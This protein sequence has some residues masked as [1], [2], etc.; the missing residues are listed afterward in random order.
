M[1]RYLSVFTRSEHSPGVWG[2]AVT[3]N[4][5]WS[6]ALY[7]WFATTW[8]WDAAGFQVS[9]RPEPVSPLVLKVLVYGSELLMLAG[10]A[11]VM[12][13]R[14]HISP[15]RKG[16]VGHQTVSDSSPPLRSGLVRSLEYAMVLVLMVLLSPM[17]SKPHFCTFL[18]PAW[19]MA[20]LAITQRSWFAG[21]CLALAIS[22]S[23]LTI[24]D[25]APANVASAAMWYG[26]VTWSAVFLFVGCGHAL[27]CARQVQATTIDTWVSRP[28]PS[29]IAA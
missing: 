2:S 17:S 10:A 5:S 15:D 12:G 9:P 22:A 29:A 8:V 1:Q 3:L 25:L 26:G 23:V 13:I 27:W 28:V 7:R 14:H 6:G 18:L 24:K 4:Q 19:L 16:G 20:R 21:L 11:W